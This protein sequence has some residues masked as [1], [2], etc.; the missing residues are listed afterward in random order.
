MLGSTRIRIVEDRGCSSY[1]SDV[2]SRSEGL[3]LST[4]D[5]SR[6]YIITWRLHK[7]NSCTLSIEIPVSNGIKDGL[8]YE[9]VLRGLYACTDERCSGPSLGET[10]G[11]RG[12]PGQ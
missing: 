8:A 5:G 7:D 1:Q 12:K 10:G 6:K 11:K 4:L 9:L 2:Q 3:G